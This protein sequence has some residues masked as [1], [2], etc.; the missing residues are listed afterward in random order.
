MTMKIAPEASFDAFETTKT[1]SKLAMLN[2]DIVFASAAGQAGAPPSLV[3]ATNNN[4]ARPSSAPSS[5]EAPAPL[6]AFEAMETFTPRA[7]KVR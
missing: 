4:K 6:S 2:N 1:T 5:L 7:S 3:D